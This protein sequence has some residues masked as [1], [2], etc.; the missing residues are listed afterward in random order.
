MRITIQIDDESGPQSQTRN[1]TAETNTVSAVGQ[2]D[3]TALNGG[4]APSETFLTH[5][6]VESDTGG[7]LSAGAARFGGQVAEAVAAASTAIDGGPASSAQ[8]G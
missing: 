6:P 1:V 7:D 2:A 4:A 5:T 8:D 3:A